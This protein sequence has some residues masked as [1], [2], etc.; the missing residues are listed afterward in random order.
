MKAT[1]TSKPQQGRIAVLLLAVVLICTAGCQ[2]F[3]MSEQDV[4]K[5]QSGQMADPKTGEA[6]AVVGTAVYYGV[7][8]GLAI[9]EML[10]K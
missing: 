10:A 5:Q 6:V 2:T 8:L 1:F 9:S 7:V 3:S 4:Q